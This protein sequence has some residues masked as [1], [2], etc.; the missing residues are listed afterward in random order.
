MIYVLSENLWTFTFTF[1]KIS[2]RAHYLLHLLF[3][4]D[5]HRLEW[6]AHTKLTSIIRISHY[7]RNYGQTFP[8]NLWYISNNSRVRIT[9]ISDRSSSISIHMHVNLCL[10]V[11]SPILS[12]DNCCYVILQIL[13]HALIRAYYHVSNR[14]STY[15]YWYI[16][17]TY[18]YLQCIYISVCVRE[19]Q[20]SVL[21]TFYEIF[22]CHSNSQTYHKCCTIFCV[23][24]QKKRKAEKNKKKREEY[25]KFIECLA[26]CLWWN[27][28]CLNIN[29]Y[30]V[31]FRNFYG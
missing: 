5:F 9:L 25:K 30:T 31:N 18:I 7:H 24:V 28:F 4:L 2:V 22:N 10:C 16:Y 19:N 13:V 6:S 27:I 12:S 23:K 8:T 29:R 11:V 17:I 14:I 20:L 21:W 3:S 1:S 26:G 15:A